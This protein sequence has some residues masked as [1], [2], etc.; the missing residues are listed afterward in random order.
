MLEFVLQQQQLCVCVCVFLCFNV[1]LK[2]DCVIC[3][4]LNAFNWEIKSIFASLFMKG[5]VSL[6]TMKE[7]THKHTC[8]GYTA[9]YPERKC[10]QRLT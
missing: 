6:E 9:E 3:N 5:T 10:L 1:L 7:N 2:C 4:S 8:K